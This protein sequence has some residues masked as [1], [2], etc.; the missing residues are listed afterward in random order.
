MGR[1]DRKVALIMGGNTGIGRAIALA[2]HREG[3][4]VAI[5][6]VAK[7][8]EAESLVRAI[9]SEGGEVLALRCG[10]TR[11]AEVRRLVSAAK[12]R[13][14]RCPAPFDRFGGHP[15]ARTTPIPLEEE[16][17]WHAVSPLS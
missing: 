7:E 16:H 5:G 13:F 10:V 9:E 12:K 11:E 6:Y 14:R 3:A 15:I 4:S 1:L 8:K 17:S 2:F